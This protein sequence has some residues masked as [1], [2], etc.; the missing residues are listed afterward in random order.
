MYAKRQ[1]CCA[2][3]EYDAS[4]VNLHVQ[5]I[6]QYTS[7]LLLFYVSQEALRRVCLVHKKKNWFIKYLHC[8]PLWQQ[9]SIIHIVTCCNRSAGEFSYFIFSKISNNFHWMC[10]RCAHCASV[11]V[12]NKCARWLLCININNNT[13]A[14]VLPSNGGC[15]AVHGL[16]YV[17][18]YSI[19][20]AYV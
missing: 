13:V 14:N 1:Q 11:C 5:V 8:M 19:R 15:S 18:W 10:A 6:T 12:W 16:W 9:L 17:K 2:A 7:H 20:S 4:N 3:I